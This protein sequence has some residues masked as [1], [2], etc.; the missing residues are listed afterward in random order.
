MMMHINSSGKKEATIGDML[1]AIM[2]QE[3]SFAK[4]ILEQNGIEKIDILEYISHNSTKENENQTDHTK[5]KKSNLDS[6][7]IELT[8][9]AKSNKIDASLSIEIKR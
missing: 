2:D 3:D 1:A 8:S 6:F 9:L 5:E 7:T 4:N